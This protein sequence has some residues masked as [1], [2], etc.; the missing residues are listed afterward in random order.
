MKVTDEAVTSGYML[1]SCAVLGAR[2][3]VDSQ[4]YYVAHT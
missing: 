2:L 3:T 1:A 4:D